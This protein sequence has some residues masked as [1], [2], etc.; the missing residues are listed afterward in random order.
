ML[1]RALDVA[2]ASKFG[3]VSLLNEH[4][5]L[6]LILMFYLSYILINLN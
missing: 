1:K 5:K 6:W 4:F 3:N 2:Y